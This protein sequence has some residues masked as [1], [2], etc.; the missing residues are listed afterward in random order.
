MV[1]VR[2]KTIETKKSNESSLIYILAGLYNFSI[3]IFSKGFSNELID[4]YDGEHFNLHG[5]LSI[6][7][8]GLAYISIY[9][10]YKQVSGLNFVFA[11]EKFYYFYIW[12]NW[13]KLNHMNLSTMINEDLLTGLFFSIYGVGDLLFGLFFLYNSCS[14]CSDVCNG[15]GEDKKD[16]ISK[17]K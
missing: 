14:N 11:I 1:D 10:R 3:I 6:L 7:L 13:M 17:N 8:W 16:N 4:K 2:E 15:N 12:I 9:N 5:N